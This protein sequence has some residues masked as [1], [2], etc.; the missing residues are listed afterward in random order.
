MY[1]PSKVGLAVAAIAFALVAGIG[2]ADAKKKK[3]TAPRC[4]ATVEGAATGT[5]ILGLGTAKAR[6][7]ARANWQ[8]TAASVHGTRYSNLNSARSVR[9][10][11][12]KGAIL[13]AKC[14]VTA[15]P[16]RY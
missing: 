6:E 4:V 10:D 8:A 7:A 3:R 15:K 14:V 9:W 13:L 11:C 2:D 1:T 5:G 16:C 12:K